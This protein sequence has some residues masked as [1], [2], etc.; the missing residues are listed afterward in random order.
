MLVL[1]DE[2]TAGAMVLDLALAL[3]H[4]WALGS[5]HELVW[6]LGLASVCGSVW[7]SALNSAL[8]SVLELVRVSVVVMAW[9]LALARAWEWAC[10][11]VRML[12]AE[13]V[14]ERVWA[15]AL[16]LDEL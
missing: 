11:S 6:A 8:D 10:V 2:A 5:A 15:S 9:A 1:S 14:S 3:V 7:D 16:E 4:E 12:D 13:L